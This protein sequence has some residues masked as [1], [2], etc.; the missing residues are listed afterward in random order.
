MP[1]GIAENAEDDGGE[2]EFCKRSELHFFGLHGY[3]WLPD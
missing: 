1:G 2:E 3:T